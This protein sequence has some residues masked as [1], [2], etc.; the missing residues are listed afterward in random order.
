MCSS[1]W[2]LDYVLYL[3]LWE[4]SNCRQTCANSQ[5]DNYFHS[6]WSKVVILSEN[7]HC[8]NLLSFWQQLFSFPFE[9]NHVIQP[10]TAW[11]YVGYP[12]VFLFKLL[13]AK[14]LSIQYLFKSTFD[15]VNT[16][17][18]LGTWN[19]GCQSLTF[20]SATSIFAVFRNLVWEIWFKKSG[21]RKVV[22]QTRIF[23]LVREKWLTRKKGVFIL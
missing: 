1:S 9:I 15:V 4:E 22:L 19:S 18:E 3:K 10:P 12:T 16:G 21:L 17:L 11:T 5:N 20:Y 8:L 13:L 2:L 23:F 7:S 14:K 6:K